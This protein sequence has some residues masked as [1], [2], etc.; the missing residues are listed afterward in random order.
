MKSNRSDVENKSNISVVNSDN[1]QNKKIEENSSSNENIV[2]ITISGTK[3][4]KAN[5]KTLKKTRIPKSISSVCDLY[6]ACRLCYN[7]D[8]PIQA[9]E[10]K[11]VHQNRE[12]LKKNEYSSKSV[13][14]PKKEENLN[15]IDIKRQNENFIRSNSKNK[16]EEEK[17][18][19]NKINSEYISI[20]NGFLEDQKNKKI[21][22]GKKL[23]FNFPNEFENNNYKASKFTLEKLTDEYEFIHSEN[24]SSENLR[25]E[26]R[27]YYAIK[28]DNISSTS[29]LRFGFQIEVEHESFLDEYENHIYLVEPRSLYV[30]YFILVMDLNE[31]NLY[32]LD[33]RTQSLIRSIK[34]LE[35]GNSK[36][37][38]SPC[39]CLMRTNDRITFY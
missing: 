29:R 24:L 14:L 25:E 28:I 3:Y 23:N 5:C 12:N 17:E 16:S 22:L 8:F 35:V 21:S 26:K 4:H 19:D 10:K 7:D 13:N 9:R 36:F 38:V 32:L 39:V 18:F 6:Q 2:Y 33:G 15:K 1:D 37:Y 20:Q 31:S 27:L 30:K 11:I 34:I